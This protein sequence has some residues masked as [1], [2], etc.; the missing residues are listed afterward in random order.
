MNPW[1]IHINNTMKKNPGVKDLKEIIKM[2]KKDYET[3]KVEI[4]NGTKG[5]ATKKNKKVGKKNKTAYKKKGKRGKSK[6]RSKK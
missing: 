5:K 6:G 2:A 1:M 3:A 4:L